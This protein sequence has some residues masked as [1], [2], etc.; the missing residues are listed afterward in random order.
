MIS[1]IVPVPYLQKVD[2]SDTESVASIS[3]SV[4]VLKQQA[5]TSCLTNI[6]SFRDDGVKGGQI[7]NAIIFMIAKD[8]L[9]LNTVEK[10]GFQYL[11]KVVTLL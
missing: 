9:P 1:D 3:A 11:M 7:T 8:G 4:S 5:L 2:S 10:T 6:K